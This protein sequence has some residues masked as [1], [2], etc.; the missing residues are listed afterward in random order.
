VLLYD[1]QNEFRSNNGIVTESAPLAGMPRMPATRACMEHWRL[2]EE[3]PFLAEPYCGEYVVHVE[4]L[5]ALL[6]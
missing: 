3:A 6:E 1:V 2:E 5:G 4:N